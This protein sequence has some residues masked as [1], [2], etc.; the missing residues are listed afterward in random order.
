MAMLYSNQTR[1]S[2]DLQSIFL[3]R[4]GR[5]WSIDRARCFRGRRLWILQSRS[6]LCRGA[7]EENQQEAKGEINYVLDFDGVISMASYGEI[8][9]ST[10]DYPPRT[11]GDSFAQVLD[12]WIDYVDCYKDYT[13]L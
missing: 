3:R 7:C 4:R 11:Q 1:N 13:F 2:I 12:F 9:S 10:A 8:I 6:F 5:R